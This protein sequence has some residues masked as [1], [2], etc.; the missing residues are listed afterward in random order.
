MKRA[1]GTLSCCYC[2]RP[3][4]QLPRKQSL[5]HTIWR[6]LIIADCELGRNEGRRY[7]GGA[8]PRLLQWQQYAAPPGSGAAECTGERLADLGVAEAVYGV[9]VDHTRGLHKCVADR[10]ADED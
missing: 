2:S 8:L 9:V 7:E 4:K 3:P 5:H 1:R 10:G 6:T